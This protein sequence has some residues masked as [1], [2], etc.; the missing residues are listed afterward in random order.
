MSFLFRESIFHKF[1][2]A[3]VDIVDLDFGLEMPF[4]L[5]SLMFA[6]KPC[7]AIIFTVAVVVTFALF[8]K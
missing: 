1:L 4:F 5:R 2:Y 6:Y 8:N 3:L 7:L